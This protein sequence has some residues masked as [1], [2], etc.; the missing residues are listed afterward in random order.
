MTVYGDISPRTA[1]Y[2]VKEL[3]ERGMPFLVLEKFGQAKPLPTNNTQSMKF[4][5]YYL[6]HDDYEDNF[7]NKTYFGSSKFDPSSYELSEAETPD[8]T[9]LDSEDITVEL[10]QYGNRIRLSDVIQDTHEDPVLQEAEDI[11]GEQAAV[12]VEKSRFNELKSGTNVYFANGSD[13]SD[14]N[15]PIDI[16]LQRKIT[17]QLKRNL[18]RPIT[19]VVR[20]TPSYGTEAVAPAFIAIA[21]PDCEN[22]IR[23]MEGFVPAEKYGSMTPFENELGKVEDVRYITTTIF[24]P[25]EDE[26]GTYD[27]GSINAISTGGDNADVYPILF[28]ARD[29]YGLVPLKGKSSI[30]PM[31]VNPK[32]SD[33]DPLAQRAHVSW[34]TYQG[35]VILNEQFMVRA[36]VA[37]T[38]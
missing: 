11:L 9:D 23:D 24:E 4:R 1:A 27:G 19:K 14:V 37:A 25:W 12:I 21:H 29:A 17:R 31:V 15:E 30:T 20:S 8:A 28:L 2:V 38:D 7:E 5:R 32:P 35:T 34:K 13:R 6:K 16:K 10:T 33:S 36:E 22:D 26:G 3:L 18:G